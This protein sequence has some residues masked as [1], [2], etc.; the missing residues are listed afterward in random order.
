VIDKQHLLNENIY[1]H[2]SYTQNFKAQNLGT[3]IKIKQKLNLNF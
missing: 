3:K 1:T 2:K